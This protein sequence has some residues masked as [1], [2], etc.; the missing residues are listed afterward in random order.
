MNKAGSQFGHLKEHAR[1]LDA[2]TGG[3]KRFGGLVS[4]VRIGHKC[5]CLKVWLIRS[6][7]IQNLTLGLLKQ[8]KW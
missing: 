4:K 7:T 1:F 8:L 5:E 6:E 3:T 2:K